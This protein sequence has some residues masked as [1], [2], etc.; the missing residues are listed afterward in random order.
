M[1][2]QKSNLVTDQINQQ[3]LETLF[4]LLP[5]R[6]R[7]HL[8]A[9]GLEPVHVPKGG[10]I[11][12]APR[13]SGSTHPLQHMEMVV[14]SDGVAMCHYLEGCGRV[15]PKCEHVRFVQPGW[16][17]VAQGAQSFEPCHIR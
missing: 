15:Q 9:A 7:L 1:L 11:R 3:T 4:G 13:S 5:L 10:K 6:R 17:Q 2:S 12:T 16:G 8:G 14:V